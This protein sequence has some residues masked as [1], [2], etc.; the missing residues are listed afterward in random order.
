MPDFKGL[1]AL[2]TPENEYLSLSPGASRPAG[3]EANHRIIRELEFAA[4][5]E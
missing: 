2:F 5:A 3:C 4:A 1:N